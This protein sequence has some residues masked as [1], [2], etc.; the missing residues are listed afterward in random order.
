[1]VGMMW[2]FLLLLLIIVLAILV[3]LGVAYA[4]DQA[5]RRSKKY[6]RKRH[7][8]STSS[9]S[10][11]ST[12]PATGVSSSSSS[13]S[14]SSEGHVLHPSVISSRPNGA[15]L[16]ALWQHRGVVV[17][18][19]YII[20][21]ND[22]VA[23]LDA[24]TTHVCQATTAMVANLAHAAN[25][26]NANAV[27]TD[28]V[29]N[30]RYD[31]ALR[32]FAVSGVCQRLLDYLRENPSIASIHED[33]VIGLSPSPVCP[34]A[35]PS[36]QVVPWGPKRVGGPSSSFRVGGGTPNVNVDV[37]IIDTGVQLNH[38][39][40]RVVTPGVSFVP[41]QSSANDQNGHGTHVAGIVGA[42]DNLYGVVGVCPGAKI[43]PI[44][45]L[46]ASGS[47]QFS[48]VIAGVNY[49]RQLKMANRSRLMV[50]NMSLGASV[51]TSSYNVLDVAVANCIAADV[52][53]AVAAGNSSSSASTF[54]PA[55][56]TTAICVGAMTEANTFASYSN[57]GSAVSILAP[58]SNMLSTYINSK[59]VLLSGTS[60]A[61]PVVAGIVAD[62]LVKNPTKKPAQIKSA[63]ITSAIPSARNPPVMTLPRN[64]SNRCIWMGNL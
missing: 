5:K 52:P 16:A 64:T 18:Q 27:P 20:V 61:A 2:W 58:G 30:H 28:M 33:A 8:S 50:A 17:P 12:V 3:V 26:A 53:F 43:H 62:Y 36:T 4:R 19:A 59:Y 47:G 15:A 1:M 46:D 7:H 42:V 56:V 31:S 23:D 10:S 51:G 35:P 57:H 37:F 39:D 13:S 55:H 9:N 48:W 38:P 25:A 6:R 41:K 22:S 45:V 24:A 34:M 11:T 14:S 60:M 63:L 54:S 44:R 21:M 32:G 29:V 49:V 40:L